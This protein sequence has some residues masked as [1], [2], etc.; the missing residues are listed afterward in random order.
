MA[1]STRRSPLP[2]RAA[3]STSGL[4]ACLAAPA[5]PPGSRLVDADLWTGLA[6]GASA[7]AACAGGGVADRARCCCCCCCE[8]GCV[9]GRPAGATSIAAV[10]GPGGGVGRRPCCCCCAAPAGGGGGVD[11]CTVVLPALPPRPGAPP[12]PFSRTAPRSWPRRSA[13]SARARTRPRSSSMLRCTMSFCLT[14][15][16]SAGGCG[17]GAAPAAARAA[18]AGKR[19]RSQLSSGSVRKGKLA[20]PTAMA[21]ARGGELLGL[22]RMLHQSAGRRRSVSSTSRRRRRLHPDRPR[23]HPLLAGAEADGGGTPCIA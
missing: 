9:G 8:V 2:E 12:L 19:S 17:G 20:S 23:A 10:S 1:M 15:P 11:R 7:V 18:A 6:A 16:S 5:P 4:A 3:C 14:V 22:Q 13:S 21:C